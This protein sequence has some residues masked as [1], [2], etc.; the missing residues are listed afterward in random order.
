[1]TGALPA[2]TAGAAVGLQ[3]G[4]AATRIEVDGW[5]LAA[6]LGYLVVL[7]AIGAYS[8]RFSSEGISEFFVGGRKMN[9]FVV[10]LSAVV[11]GRSAWLLLGVTGMAYA[12]GASAL[13]AVTGYTVA[14][15][16]LFFYFAGRLRRFSDRYDCITIPDFFAARF[17]DDD[18]RLRAIL[19]LILLVFMVSYVSAQ[20]VGGGKAIGASFGLGHTAGVLLT[21]GI[22]VLYTTMAGGFLAVSL[23]DTL[24]AF[25]MLFALL[26]LPLVAIPAAGGW[27]AVRA[28]LAAYQPGFVDPLNLG[29]GAFL[30]MVGIGLGSPGNPHIIVRYMSIDDA[31]QLRWAAGV[32]TTWNVLMG[33]GAVLIGLAGRVFVPETSM[34][35]GADTE[36]LFPVLARMHLHPALFGV[37]AAP[38]FAA[39]MSTADSQLLVA[40]SS[41]VRDVYQSV[42]RRDR[43]VSERR[44]VILSRSIVAI[45]VGAALVMG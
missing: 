39:I 34:L 15:F 18:G 43:E 8:T 12:T 26:G 4:V 3:E 27:G 7:V 44:L 13:W 5:S 1:M 41:V 22:V 28:E 45:L 40:A 31:D 25:L 10:A 2:L 17:G 21:A 30:G 9:R 6:F 38:I 35:P 14:E 20:F 33:A 11:S 24:Q 23:T 42:L 36:N 32:G 19:A 37:V 29:F 16:F